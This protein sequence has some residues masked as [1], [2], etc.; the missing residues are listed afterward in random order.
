MFTGIIQAL[1][2]LDSLNRKN[3]A[4][5]A[6]RMEPSA[7]VRIGDSVAVDGA[8]LTV[9]R[10]DGDRFTFDLSKESLALSRFADLGKGS[11]L[12]IEL[13]LRMQDF[14]G[15]HLVSGH[16]DGTVRARAVRK[17]SGAATF[18]FTYTDH[19][20]RRYLVHKG[21]V[22]LNGISLTLTQVQASSFSVEVI[23]HTLKATNLQ[24]LRVGERVNV[25]LDLIAKYLYNLQVRKTDD[26]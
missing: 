3:F 10:V 19:A 6:I 5:L 11:V 25:E 13:P 18:S 15:G 26:T 16:L 4:E 23:P 9:A 8:C 2:R 17:G 12:N 1:G 20:W 24:H 14:L 22:C 21:S 7:A